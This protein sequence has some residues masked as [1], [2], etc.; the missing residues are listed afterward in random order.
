MDIG[1]H[2]RTAGTFVAI[3]VRSLAMG[4]QLDSYAFHSFLR[5][6]I[7]YPSWVNGWLMIISADLAMVPRRVQRPPK[8]VTVGA[9]WTEHWSRSAGAACTYQ[10]ERQASSAA[11]SGAK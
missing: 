4:H 10:G 11:T 8:G 6:C 3:T 7:L 5:D 9:E 1:A 2:H